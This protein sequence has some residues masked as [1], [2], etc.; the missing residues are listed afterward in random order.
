MLWLYVF[1]RVI[2]AREN[3]TEFFMPLAG[4]TI[5][6]GAIL[7][8]TYPSVCAFIHVFV[9]VILCLGGWR[10][11]FTT[12]LPTKFSSYDLCATQQLM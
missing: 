11:H 8:S 2:D 1:I 12:G 7:F 3:Y 9:C 4:H 10:R 6:G 5:G